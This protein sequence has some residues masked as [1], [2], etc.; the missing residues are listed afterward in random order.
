M[1][2]R[3][4]R[5]VIYEIDYIF[6]NNLHQN[7]LGTEY[8]EKYLNEFYLSSKMFWDNPDGSLQKDNEKKDKNN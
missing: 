7:K 2:K 4:F 3:K 1:W 5:D 6:V 8:N